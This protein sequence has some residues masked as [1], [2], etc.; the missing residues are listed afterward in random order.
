MP[1]RILA[2][3]N[4]WQVR[5]WSGRQHE[6]N[7]K[8]Y[9]IITQKYEKYYHNAK[10]KK[11]IKTIK[12]YLK[13]EKTLK[14][15]K[16]IRHM[17]KYQKLSKSWKTLKNIKKLSKSRKNMIIKKYRSGGAVGEIPVA[18]HSPGDIPAALAAPTEKHTIPD[19]DPPFIYYSVSFQNIPKNGYQNHKSQ[20]GC[21]SLKVSMDP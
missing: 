17:K 11:I 4:Q 15:T 10:N 18:A 16:N 5:A 3:D 13:L 6:I 19:S 12:N 2:F 14:N 21:E 9:V 7:Q 1:W 20:V 8:H